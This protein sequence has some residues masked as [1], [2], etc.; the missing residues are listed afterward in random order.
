MSGKSKFFVIMDRIYKLVFAFLFIS[1]IF[2]FIYLILQATGLWERINSLE[3][4]QEWVISGGVYSFLIFMF[5]QFLQ[6][7]ILQIP[8]MFVTIFGALIFGKWQAFFMSYT[9]VMLGSFVMFFIGRKCGKRFLNWLVGKSTAE[10]WVEKM[11]GGK[12]LFFLM[13]LFPLFP[14]D[15]LCVAAGI[16]N[17]SFAFFFWTNVI[18]RGIGLLCTV[19]LGTGSVIPFSG[20]GLAVWAII[21]VFVALIFF[22]S[23]KYKDKIDKILVN[24]TKKKNKGDKK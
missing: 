8:A 5:I 22:A 14:D 13:M 12:Y 17:M 1:L 24:F 20:W 3:K 15:I 19:F 10:K 7:T 21:V 18:A 2:S 9:A 11:T 16:T 6:T 23:V 4:M